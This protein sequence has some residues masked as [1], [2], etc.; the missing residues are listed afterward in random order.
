MSQLQ[1][2]VPVSKA[3]QRP[4]MV[5]QQF[6]DSAT[7]L[8]QQSQLEQPVE[9]PQQ[10]ASPMTVTVP[11]R[12]HGNTILP[13]A[14]PLPSPTAQVQP[15]APV[16]DAPTDGSAPVAPVIAPE[17]VQL[18]QQLEA[19]RQAFAQRE[20]QWQQYAQA[21]SQQ[22]TEAQKAQYELEQLKQREALYQK[23]ANDETFAGLESVDVDDAR[24]IIQMTADTLAQPLSETKAAMNAQ[25]QQLQQQLQ[26]TQQAT[27]QQMAAL[28]SM[29]VRDE[30]LT[31]HPDFFAL[32]EKPEFRAF[33]NQ[34]NGSSVETRE[35]YAIREYNAGNAAA[36]I[37]LVNQYKGAV[38]KVESMQTVAPVQVAS[39]SAVSDGAKG[40]PV[41]YTLRDLL[42]ARHT[43]QITP[44]QFTRMLA[45]LRAAQ[46]V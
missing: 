9:Q 39:A 40:Q 45:E 14:A 33:L 21:Q 24:R 11:N 15:V 18:Q 44:D 20:Q 27:A 35:Q 32:Y 34:R 10:P 4:P 7:Q 37:D 46:P 17:Q 5:T 6:K 13:S 22:L 26:Q 8:K 19:E 41:S 38:P 25:Y 12:R 43:G 29:K 30:L 28:Q 23:L 3:F 36:V 1:P 31:A 2:D 16:T 42:D